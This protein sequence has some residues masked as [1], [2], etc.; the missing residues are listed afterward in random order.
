M[1][2]RG[3]CVLLSSLVRAFPSSSALLMLHH[4]HLQVRI[5]NIAGFL[6]MPLS[7]FRMYPT[8]IFAKMKCK[9]AWKIKILAP[10]PQAD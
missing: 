9:M 2:A 3:L 4:K 10:I 7:W 1:L 8:M 5:Y 6:L